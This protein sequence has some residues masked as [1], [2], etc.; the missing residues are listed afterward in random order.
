[1]RLWQT[2][3]CYTNGATGDTDLA[4]EIETVSSIPALR[5][6]AP[7]AVTRGLFVGMNAQTVSNTLIRHNPKALSCMVTERPSQTS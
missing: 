4:L 5:I 3:V 1:M 2:A 6:A 7:T